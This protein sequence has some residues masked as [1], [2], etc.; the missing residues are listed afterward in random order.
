MALQCVPKPWR[1]FDGT[2]RRLFVQHEVS[3]ELG[4]TRQRFRAHDS[5][6]LGCELSFGVE[7]L[8][9]EVPRLVL[10][11]LANVFN[12]IHSSGSHEGGI[13]Q[14]YMIRGHEN[15][16]SLGACCAVEH[17]QKTGEG[18][19]LTISLYSWI[20]F[21]KRRIDI[22]QKDYR[23]GRKHSH[24][25]VESVI[26]QAL[27]IEV[28]NTDVVLQMSRKRHDEGGL[29]TARRPMEQV[30]TPEWNTPIDIPF[31]AGRKLRDVVDEL[32]SGVSSQH[33]G[34]ERPPPPRI[35]KY[36]PLRHQGC[37]D[38]CFSGF[39]LEGHLLGLVQQLP[40]EMPVP[41]SG[42]EHD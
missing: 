35:P 25:M 8:E 1:I 16:S 10:T 27:V 23:M 12:D 39:L 9:E 2:C 6:K 31:C 36:F 19:G 37:V 38:D 3:L 21:H 22:F 11:S 32:L 24:K 34:I 29:S 33:Y 40:E 15:Q 18:D 5:S 14:L 41:I 7:E 13:K 17:V 20:S 28:E 30:P 26:R 42:R 4:H